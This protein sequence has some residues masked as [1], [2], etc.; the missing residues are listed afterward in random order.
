MYHVRSTALIENEKLKS[1]TYT[2]GWFLRGIWMPERDFK[3]VSAT[4][5][6]ASS[7]NGNRL[8]ELS[9][10]LKD[11]ANALAELTGSDHPHRQIVRRACRV[12]EEE[13]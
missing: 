1:V 6:H 8:T 3:R 10:A 13:S 4:E 12:L 2:V 7:L 5:A 11:C 9:A